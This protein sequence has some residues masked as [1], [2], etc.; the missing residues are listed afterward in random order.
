MYHVLEQ[1]RPI[2]WENNLVIMLDQRKLPLEE[3]YVECA[4]YKNVADAI[5][6]MVVRG[7]PAIGVAAAM[8]MALGA[9]GLGVAH[10]AQFMDRLTRVGDTLCAT[11]PTAVNLRWGVSR[12]LDVARAAEGQPLPQIIERLR[13][14][15]IIIYEEDLATNRQLGEFGAPLIADGDHILTHCNAGALATAGYG[16]ALSVLYAAHAAGRRFHVYADETRPFLQG[17]RLTAWELQKC[18][19]PVTV[20]T[21]NMAASLMQQGKISKI[22]VGADRIAAN[23]DVAN[24]IGTYGLAV[25]AQHHHIP[26]YV[27][28]PYSTV[29]LQTPTGQHIPIEERPAEEVTHI[30]ATQIT[31]DGVGIYNPAFDVTPA[32]LITAILTDRGNFPLNP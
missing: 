6:Q 15:A 7:A 27:V 12:M 20:I 14:E 25:L 10:Y 11:R 13:Q 28:A 30:G 22:F 17:A 9:M 2:R 16:T 29:D 1:I 24:K 32:H 8:G 18:G 21:D 23:G 31:P 5:R 19:I 4:D 3:I 26:F